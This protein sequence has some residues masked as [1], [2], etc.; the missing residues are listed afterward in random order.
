MFSQRR[1]VSDVASFFF[2]LKGGGREREREGEVFT[3]QHKMNCVCVASYTYAHIHIYTYTYE[4]K[5]CVD[6]GDN[7]QPNIEMLAESLPWK[8]SG[9]VTAVGMKI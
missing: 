1:Q 4:F 3:H 2:F 5:G 7:A 8:D 6:G 9:D